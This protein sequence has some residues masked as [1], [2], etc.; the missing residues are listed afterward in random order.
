MQAATS[1]HAL[2][3]VSA[4]VAPCAVG[5]L[6]GSIKHVGVPTAS[7]AHCR[8]MQSFPLGQDR[9]S[10]APKAPSLPDDHGPNPLRGG[11]TVG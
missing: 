6:R 1:N 9:R 5:S 7:S 4:D 11:A 2:K 3:V 8:P 10:A